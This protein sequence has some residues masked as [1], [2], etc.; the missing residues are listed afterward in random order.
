VNIDLSDEET[1]FAQLVSD[2]GSPFF[3]SA[4]GMLSRGAVLQ[5][6]KPHG[7]GFGSRQQPRVQR[8]VGSQPS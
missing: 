6:T 1:T 7:P 4:T 5:R 8:A 2:N 3:V